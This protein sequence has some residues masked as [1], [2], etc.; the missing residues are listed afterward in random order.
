[1]TK[2][3]PREQHQIHAELD[4][5]LR[6]NVTGSMEIVAV[7]R[8]K[9]IVNIHCDDGLGRCAACDLPHPCR[10]HRVAFGERA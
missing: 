3:T 6:V 1:M 4:E 10:T 2:L 5:V 7:H 8:L 9:S